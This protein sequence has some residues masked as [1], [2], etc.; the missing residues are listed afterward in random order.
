[1]PKHS[2]DDVIAKTR[3]HLKSLKACELISPNERGDFPRNTPPSKMGGIYC[4]YENGKPLYVGRTQNLRERVLEHRRPSGD[5]YTSSFAF[6]IAKKDFGLDRA[7]NTMRSHLEKDPEFARL[8]VAAK[9]RVRK[10]SVR[11]VEI[12]DPIEQTI[13]EVCAHMELDTPE[14]FNNF[15]TH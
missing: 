2:F 1:M 13:F 12:H 6:N 9:E 7:R 10:M 14:D 15:G 4:F 3:E 5:H 8:F 11:F